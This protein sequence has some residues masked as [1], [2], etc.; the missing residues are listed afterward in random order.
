MNSRLEGSDSGDGFTSMAGWISIVSSLC[1]VLVLSGCAS[2]QAPSSPGTASESDRLNQIIVDQAGL[3]EKVEAENKRLQKENAEL[4]TNSTAQTLLRV[5]DYLIENKPALLHSLQDQFSSSKEAI[6]TAVGGT[7]TLL[8][9]EIEDIFVYKEEVVLTVLLLWSNPDQSGGVGRVA[10]SWDPAKD[11]APD[12]CALIGQQLISAQELAN[13]TGQG[14]PVA[15]TELQGQQIEQTRPVQ[16][17]SRSWVS[18][19][20]KNVML[21]TAVKTAGAAVSVFLVHA[22]DAYFN[23]GSSP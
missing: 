11:F 13:L 1:L 19:E 8:D 12:G 21:Q 18:D 17:Q 16:I 22:V 15:E 7:G 9:Y 3:R 14:K 20:S 5:N 4:R 2:P 10:L 6:F 23:A